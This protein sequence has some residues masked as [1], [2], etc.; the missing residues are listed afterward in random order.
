M[1]ILKRN[2]NNGFTLIEI[3]VVITIIS[4]MTTISLPFYRNINMNLNLSGE[5]RD[6]ASDLRQAQQLSVT[7]QTNYQVIIN[8]TENS[9]SIVNSKTLKKIKEK[10]LKNDITILA[11][12]GLINNTIEFNAT[13]AAISTGNIILT[14]PNLKQAIIEIKPSGYV[15]IYN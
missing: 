15:K 1:K 14:N 12:S 11:I 8:Q 7:E 5:I 3:I 13:G 10:K 9:Y 6:L 2:N 4:L